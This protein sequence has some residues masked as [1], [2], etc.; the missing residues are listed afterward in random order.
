[1]DP[2][3]QDNPVDD[4]AGAEVDELLMAV[5]RDGFTLRYCN[6]P[7]QPTVI[8]GTYDW[9]DWVDLVVIRGID[10]VV[11]ARVLTASVTDVFAPELA[12]WVYVGEAKQA[13]RALLDLP[14]PDHPQA[15]T[16][17]APAPRSLHVPVARQSPVTVR[18]PSA[19][20]ARTRQM[21]LGAALLADTAGIQNRNGMIR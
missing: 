21:R 10:D 9:G 1:M 11:S 8:V 3:S 18:P 17:S 16:T 14:H 2:H 12:V 6:G 20:A 7:R 5:T 19:L 4:P 15:P 13:L